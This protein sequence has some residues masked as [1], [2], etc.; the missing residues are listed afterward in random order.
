MKLAFLGTPGMAVPSLQALVAA[1][2]EVDIVITGADKRRGRGSELTA[3][4][5]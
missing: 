1:G 5:L 3:N 2:H 4:M